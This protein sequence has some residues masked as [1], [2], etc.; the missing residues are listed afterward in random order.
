MELSVTLNGCN[1][2]VVTEAAHSLAIPLEFNGEQPN[3][4]GA[5]LASAQTLES[6]GFLGDTKRGGSCNVAQLT[7]V[8]HCNGTHT[9]SVSH[10][11]DELVPVGTLLSPLLISCALVTVQPETLENCAES[12]FPNPQ[13][14]DL[15]VS[16][17][18]LSESLAQLPAAAGCQAIVIR[19]LPN[20][21]DKLRRAYASGQPPVFFS[22]E[23]MQ[24][25]LG[26][27]HLLV[28]FPSLD[29]MYD[30]GQLDNHHNFWQVETGKHQKNANTLLERTVTEMVFAPDQLAD[31]LYLLNLQIP[32]FQS[33]AAPSRPVLMPLELIE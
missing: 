21:T 7:L 27:D 19:T 26:F 31:G 13:A 33:D 9:E 18:R 3:H 2:R 24:L 28:D 23:A 1:Y 15:V 22:S 8:P 11:I 30:Q 10:I 25:L 32:P 4:F 14:G 16:G 29:K 6:D 5:P 20:N 17:R 12:Y